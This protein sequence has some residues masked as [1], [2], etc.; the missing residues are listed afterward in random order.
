MIFRESEAGA[1][2]CL[3]AHSHET[4]FECQSIAPNVAIE[5]VEQL[6]ASI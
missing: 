4:A 3:V 1:N 5:A 6:R 2:L